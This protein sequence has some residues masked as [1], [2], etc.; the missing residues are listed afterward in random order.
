M[1]DL[2]SFG[3]LFLFSSRKV[4][5]KR[6]WGK[7]QRETK[8]EEKQLIFYLW[9]ACFLYIFCSFGP[10]LPFCLRKRSQRWFKTCSDPWTCTSYCTSM[11]VTICT[12]IR[13]PSRIISCRSGKSRNFIEITVTTRFFGQKS[14]SFTWP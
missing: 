13:L 6:K 14:S 11:A 10:S 2:W 5:R 4:K 9:S 3:A 8:A 12:R 1:H 7:K